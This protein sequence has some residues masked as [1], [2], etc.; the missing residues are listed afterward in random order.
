MA[1]RGLALQKECECRLVFRRA[2]SAKRTLVGSQPSCESKSGS[3]PL[4]V[5]KSH[6]A[7]LHLVSI[8]TKTFYDYDWE[9]P[10]SGINAF[11][12]VRKV[13]LRF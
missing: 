8:T 5:L 1:T 4:M 2:P 13:L 7:L 3:S 11:K 12:N 6:C 10:I 9:K